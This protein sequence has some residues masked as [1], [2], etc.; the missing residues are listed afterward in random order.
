MR[1]PLK[2]R[3]WCAVRIRFRSRQGKMWAFRI[4]LRTEWKCVFRLFRIGAKIWIHSNWNE[5]KKLTEITEVKNPLSL[6]N[7]GCASSLTFFFCTKR[8]AKRSHFPPSG[9]KTNKFNLINLHKILFSDRSEMRNAHIFPCLERKRIR[10]AHPI[11]PSPINPPPPSLELGGIVYSDPHP[12]P[13]TNCGTLWNQRCVKLFSLYY[14]ITN[15]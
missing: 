2:S 9:T 6:P 5:A 14:R 7:L 11:I 3:L 1:P 15:S 10:T 12:L 4:S 8:N 13:D